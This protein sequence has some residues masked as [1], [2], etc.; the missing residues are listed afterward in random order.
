MAG[1]SETASRRQART[2][3]RREQV[4][5]AA[6]A[7]FRN[8]GFH[9]ASMARIAAAAEMSVGHIYQYFPS[10]DAI[11]VALCERNFVGFELLVPEPSPTRTLDAWIARFVWWIEPARAPL[12]VEIM[13]EAARNPR[14]AEV[15]AAIDARFREIMRQSLLPLVAPLPAEEIEDRL[16]AV[17]MLAHGMTNRVAAGADPRRIMAAFRLAV[18]ALLAV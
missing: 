11:I 16:E 8:E 9:G 18:R 10:K 17:N 12:T 14:V 1:I 15:V 3:R 13:A 7:C 6:E 2:E 4:L 5:D